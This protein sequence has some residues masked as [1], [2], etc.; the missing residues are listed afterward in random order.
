VKAL[1]L[2]D[3]WTELVIRHEEQIRLHDQPSVVV[4]D[5]ICRRLCYTLDSAD[6]NQWVL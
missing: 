5:D 3:E 1:H 6:E 4:E 2:Y